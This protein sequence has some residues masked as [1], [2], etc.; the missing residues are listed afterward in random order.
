MH[1]HKDFCWPGFFGEK[2]AAYLARITGPSVDEDKLSISGAS[3]LAMF[4]LG[5]K[6]LHSAIRQGN[7]KS[8]LGSENFNNESLSLFLLS[9]NLSKKIVHLKTC[10]LPTPNVRDSSHTQITAFKNEQNNNKE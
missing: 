10:W 2:P 5:Y 4:T 1:K 8:T 3:A 9:L 7:S 6:A